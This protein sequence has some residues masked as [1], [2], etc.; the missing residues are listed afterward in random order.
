MSNG[1]LLGASG[2]RS[3][4]FAGADDLKYVYLEN[5]ASTFWISSQVGRSPFASGVIL[6]DMLLGIGSDL[7]LG[8]YLRPRLVWMSAPIKKEIWKYDC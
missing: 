5:A 2:G 8:I 4:W 1:S 3:S 6:A 7:L